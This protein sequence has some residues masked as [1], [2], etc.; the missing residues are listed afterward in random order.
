[1][2]PVLELLSA[3]DVWE[4]EAVEGMFP[5][6]CEQRPGYAHAQQHKKAREVAYAHLQGLEGGGEREAEGS[7]QFLIFHLLITFLAPSSSHRERREKEVKEI[8][9]GQKYRA[10]IGQMECPRS[11]KRQL[12]ATSVTDVAV[13]G[14][15]DP[16]VIYV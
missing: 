6:E 3:A 10:K 2:E 14:E 11:F 16:R 8:T 13:G 7:L 9:M 4:D 15:V 5:N 1:M 12:E